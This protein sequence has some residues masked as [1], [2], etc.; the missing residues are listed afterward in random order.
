[1]I[2]IMWFR[3]LIGCEMTQ[4][5]NILLCVAIALSIIF[6][7][8]VH[9]F[10]KIETHYS[11]S[12]IAQSTEADDEGHSHSHSHDDGDEIVSSSLSSHAHSHNPIDHSHDLPVIL[13]KPPFSQ[14]G[15]I[16]SV[17]EAGNDL[18]IS[19]SPHEL[20]RPP[21]NSFLVVLS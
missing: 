1:M 15:K 7:S 13:I 19:H 6:G 12:S 18:A 20:D 17:L 14:A 16:L 8:F 4:K 11:L 21:Q 10:V 5:K 3:K 2:R 9:S